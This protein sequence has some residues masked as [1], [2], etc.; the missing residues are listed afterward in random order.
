MFMRQTVDRPRLQIIRPHR[1][2]W[3]AETPQVAGHPTR[4]RWR[5]IPYYLHPLNH[6][7]APSGGKLPFRRDGEADGEGE[8]TSGL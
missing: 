5:V 7:E 6:D 3:A 4:R 8:A 1:A 2:C